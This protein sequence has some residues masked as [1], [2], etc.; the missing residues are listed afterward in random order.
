MLKKEDIIQIIEEYQER[1]FLYCVSKVKNKYDADDIM[2]EVLLFLWQK[3]ESLIRDNIQA[4]L[5]RCI[6]IHIKR[7]FSKKQKFENANQYIDE[8]DEYNL[9]N[10]T[11]NEYVMDHI[12][13]IDEKTLEYIKHKLPAE[14]QKLFQ[15]RYIN[16]MLLSEISKEIAV[17]ISTVGNRCQKLNA[18]IQKIID[19]IYG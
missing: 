2:G 3:K 12:E 15:Y 19:E 17:P 13:R 5:Y 11:D 18:N 10:I 6:D 1:L 9:P 14:Q 4:W 16:N 8:I 7:F